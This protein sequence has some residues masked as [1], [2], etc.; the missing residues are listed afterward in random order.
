L[1]AEKIVVKVVSQI[2]YVRLKTSIES[3]IISQVSLGAVF[4]ASEK[5]GDWYKVALPPD[6]QGFVVEGYIHSTDVQL[7]VAEETT[8]VQVSPTV[9]QTE[10][11][12]PAVKEMEKVYRPSRESN[13]QSSSVFRF[14]PL[15][16][17]AYN[18]YYAEFKIMLSYLSRF[19][20]LN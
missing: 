20:I 15:W 3:M 19:L 13:V 5:S 7:V 14:F 16:A 12:K 4:E 2:A 11:K 17:L 6:E 18:P 1:R 10:A 8:S 9:P